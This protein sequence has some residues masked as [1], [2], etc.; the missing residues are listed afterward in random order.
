MSEQVLV[1]PYVFRC[2]GLEFV[3][4]PTE[5]VTHADNFM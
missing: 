3:A 1:G 5:L 2:S 4:L